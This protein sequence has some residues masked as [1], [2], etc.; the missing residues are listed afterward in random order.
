MSM[1]V[2]IRSE[3]V[4]LW[5][6]PYWAIHVLVPLIGAIL[7]IFYFVFYSSVNGYE[8]LKLITELTAMVFPLLISVIVGLSVSQEEKSSHFQTMLTVPNRCKTLLAK[9]SVLYLSGVISLVALYA[10]FS[11][12]A[13]ISITEVFPWTFML[14][15]VFGLAFGSFVIYTLHLLLSLKFGLG[16]SL[17]WGVFE[18]LQCILFSNI[19][20]QGIWRYIPFA[21]SVNWIKDVFSGRLVEHGLEWI[22][23]AVLTDCILVAVL[24]WF[25]HWEGRK[26]YE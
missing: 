6:T 3:L 14:Q 7:F 10:L 19:E 20:L 22:V 17:F 15:A 9:L 23:I 12:G 13:S 25:S 1:I 5:H 4:K 11:I 26:N 21:W 16:I 24:F 2:S 18:C 8:K